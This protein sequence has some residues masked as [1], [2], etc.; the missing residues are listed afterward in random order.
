MTIFNGKKK[1]NPTLQKKSEK[2]RKNINGY[3][4]VEENS[5]HQSL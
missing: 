2:P 3:Q 1:K 4:E 5:V